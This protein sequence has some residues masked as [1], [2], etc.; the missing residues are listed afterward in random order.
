MNYTWFEDIPHF[1]MK[2]G[3]DNYNMKHNCNKI[4]FKKNADIKEET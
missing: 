1:G 3:G 2:T 4:L